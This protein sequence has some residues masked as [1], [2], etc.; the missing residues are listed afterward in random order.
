MVEGVLISELV[1]FNRHTEEGV[2]H[3]VAVTAADAFGR[4]WGCRAWG[5][6]LVFDHRERQGT[7]DLVGKYG[8]SLS[9]KTQGVSRAAKAE[10]HR[11]QTGEA[12]AAKNRVIS[13]VVVDAKSKT[14]AEKPTESRDAGRAS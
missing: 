8:C 10:R 11:L 13:A 14:T 6:K 12:V 1:C 4:R 9:R 2:W 7:P 5:W 3:S